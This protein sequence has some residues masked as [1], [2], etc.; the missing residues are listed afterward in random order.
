MLKKQ[1]ADGQNSEKTAS[2]RF[3]SLPLEALV[4]VQDFL[5][6][7][8]L[9]VLARTS[10]RM[11]SMLGLDQ[12]VS[13]LLADW[14]LLLSDL[15]VPL[16]PK[17]VKPILARMYRHGLLWK[18]VDSLDR[19]NLRESILPWL[20]QNQHFQKSD[21]V[22]LE[23][24]SDLVYFNKNSD[25]F[26][27][28]DDYMAEDELIQME[29]KQDLFNQ[30][31][32]QTSRYSFYLF[33]PRHAKY[34]YFNKLT[35]KSEEFLVD[36]SG[37][38]W[39]DERSLNSQLSTIW[40]R[41][42]HVDSLVPIPDMPNHLQPEIIQHPGY[43]D[44][45]R[46]PTAIG[47]RASLEDGSLFL[48]IYDAILPRRFSGNACIKLDH[49][50][51]AMPWINSP[52]SKLLHGVIETV[53][54]HFFPYVYNYGFDEGRH[55]QNCVRANFME[56]FLRIVIWDDVSPSTTRELTLDLPYQGRDRS[57]ISYPENNSEIT[58]L[59]KKMST[60]SGLPGGH[61]FDK[62]LEA[63]DI[64]LLKQ[65]ARSHG[66]ERPIRNAQLTCGMLRWHGQ[67]EAARRTLLKTLPQ[68]LQAKVNNRVV[69]PHTIKVSP[70]IHRYIPPKGP[71]MPISL[72]SSQALLDV[73]NTGI[74]QNYK[75]SHTPLETCL[76]DFG[77]ILLRDIL[78]PVMEEH[79]S[80][81]AW[82]K[83]V[84]RQNSS[85]F[86][87]VSETECFNTFKSMLVFGLALK[88]PE[89][90]NKCVSLLCYINE[91]TDTLL[92]TFNVAHQ[93]QFNYYRT[94]NHLIPFLTSQPIGDYLNNSNN[95]H[96]THP[97][98]FKFLLLVSLQNEITTLSKEKPS[99]RLKTILEIMRFSKG[100]SGPKPFEL[101]DAANALYDHILK[102]SNL[103]PGMRKICACSTVLDAIAIA[104]GLPPYVD[105]VSSYLA[106]PR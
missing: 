24:A 2:N 25:V 32:S 86:G 31:A 84:Y 104:S 22:Y 47:T 65:Y 42:S 20:I 80:L 83:A 88:P 43:A 79:G 62:H 76:C 59:I 57:M 3:S 6:R 38:G 61:I 55:M 45:Y 94:Q 81:Q 4:S 48:A 33:Y 29:S 78:F 97:N 18:I 73:F 105:E 87:S 14:E 95:I 60:L 92:T 7:E 102:G 5:P 101:L 40:N 10:K 56:G 13:K 63:T 19:R 30:Y 21:L 68:G 36:H 12:L 100:P 77:F 39:G 51:E 16:N 26:V 1:N 53:G 58:T 41:T 103:S 99:N 106:P 9:K 50:R 85:L 69:K 34:I 23:L 75:H 70:T 52:D 15:S 82:V 35:T 46:Y 93:H 27:I 44:S 98:I 8:D 91:T 96:Q 28:N 71:H 72:D 54:D 66:D 49:L 64:A 74:L 17:V 37:H 67:H 89:T 11:A 90:L